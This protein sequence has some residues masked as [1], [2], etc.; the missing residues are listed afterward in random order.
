ML[1]HLTNLI[2]IGGACPAAVAMQ[3]PELSQQFLFCLSPCTR[4]L[5]NSWCPLPFARLISMLQVTKSTF[6]PRLLLD[7]LTVRGVRAQNF[8]CPR[9]V[10]GLAWQVPGLHGVYTALLG[11]QGGSGGGK[12]EL[13]GKSGRK[14]GMF[15]LNITFP[16]YETGEFSRPREKPA[17]VS[18]T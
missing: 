10:A 14:R 17:S 8:P 15:V 5:L 3:L 1:S 6:A 12:A 18:S 16:R 11:L 13:V 9:W 2:P 7:V 4:S